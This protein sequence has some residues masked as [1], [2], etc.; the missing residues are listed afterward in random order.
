MNKATP[1]LNVWAGLAAVLVLLSAPAYAQYTPRPLDDP[2][3]GEKFHIEGGADFWLPSTN[4]SISSEALG[5]AGSNIDLK[6]DLGATDQRFRA[7]QLMARP[8]PAHKFRFQYIP[9]KYTASSILARDVIFNGIR[10]RANLPVN[11]DFDWKAYRFGYEFD[12]VRKNKG[13][14]GFLLEAKYTDVTVKLD[15]PIE[16]QFAHA[17]GPIPAIG[18]IGRYYVVPNI[19]ITGELTAFKL[20][21]SIDERYSAHYV[22]MDIYGTVNFTNYIGV[23]GGYRSTNVGYLIKADTGALNLKG[24]YFGAVV[25][26]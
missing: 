10:Y 25:R 4:I 23:K 26:Y 15:N 19:S 24:I 20:P 8:S 6:R 2:A 18:G 21:A 13:F 7:L 5:I 1:R 3:T 9:I 12:F 14:A 22:D 17:R 11:T 16:S